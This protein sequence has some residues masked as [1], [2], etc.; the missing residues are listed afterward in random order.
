VLFPLLL[1]VCLLEKYPT[2]HLA[3][4]V[5]ISGL[6][7]WILGLPGSV[8]IGASG[9]VF[10]LFGYILASLFIAKNYFYLIPV[11]VLAYF[12]SQSILR[13]LIPKEGISFAGHFGGFVGGFI[14]GSF[15]HKRAKTR[16]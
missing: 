3:A 1:M 16:L 14:V 6:F 9:L 10:A 8:H 12:Y 11:A 5:F 7:T 4:L 2:R 13:G 15:I